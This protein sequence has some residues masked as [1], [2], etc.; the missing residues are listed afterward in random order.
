VCCVPKLGDD[1]NGGIWLE[2]DREGWM[3]LQPGLE[4][5]SGGGNDGA[6]YEFEQQFDMRLKF[7]RVSVLRQGGKR[8]WWLQETHNN[9][10]KYLSG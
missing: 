6:L 5:L 10:Y 9:L 2:N 3:W 4:A 8:V 1:L 7:G